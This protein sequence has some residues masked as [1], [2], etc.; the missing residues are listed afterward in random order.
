MS[1]NNILTHYLT[2]RRPGYYL[3]VPQKTDTISTLIYNVLHCF[4]ASPKPAFFLNKVAQRH[5][6]FCM[7]TG[8]N[9]VIDGEILP[10]A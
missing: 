10:L 9:V 1:P 6:Y 7:T 8:I 3:T 5:P 4:L 2:V